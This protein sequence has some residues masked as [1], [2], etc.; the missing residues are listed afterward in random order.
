MEQSKQKQKETTTDVKTK[1]IRKKKKSRGNL[2]YIKKGFEKNGKRRSDKELKLILNSI[3][4]GI[5]EKVVQIAGNLSDTFKKTKN[6]GKKEF[7]TAVKLLLPL[8]LYKKFKEKSRESV[9]KYKD[10][11]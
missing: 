2:H 10:I 9:K 8:P 1:E 7:S 3:I 5:D 11:V 6:I 4:E